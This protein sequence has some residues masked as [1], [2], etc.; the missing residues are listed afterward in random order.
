M[1]IDI[2]IILILLALAI[3]LVVLE[4][5]FLPGLTFAGVLSVLFY[6]GA[7]YYAF[8]HAG[9]TAGVVTL[10]GGALLT[11]VAICYFMRSRTL[12][13]MSLKTDIAETAPTRVDAS[14]RVGAEGLALSRLN[15]M[16]TVLIEGV[17]VEARS[18]GD[19]IDESTR[20]RVVKIEPTTVVVSP[21]DVEGNS[22]NN[23]DKTN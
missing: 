4:I 14:I 5:F 6:G 9:V 11:I 10:L 3:L 7:I 18:T 8:S 17:T 19:F 15:P 2:V 20:V 13:K 23:L 12:D 16:G 1:L 22:I 21:V